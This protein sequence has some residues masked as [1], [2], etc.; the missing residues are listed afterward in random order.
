MIDKF[1]VGGAE[2]VSNQL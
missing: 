1:F 2:S